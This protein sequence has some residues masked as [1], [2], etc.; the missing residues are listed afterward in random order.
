[1]QLLHK[2]LMFL[3][4]IPAF[5]FAQD[6]TLDGSFAIGSGPNSEVEGARELSNGKIIVYGYF[7][8]WSG[9][10]ANGII[11]LNSNCSIDQTFT[12]SE[13]VVMPNYMLP[14]KNGQL[15]ACTSGRIIKMNAN[16]SLDESFGIH[17][18]QNNSI[19]GMFEDAQGN[20]H[21]MGDLSSY[22]GAPVSSGFRI[23]TNGV[24]DRSFFLSTTSGIAVYDMIETL[25]GRL[26]LCMASNQTYKGISFPCGIVKVNK[27]GSIFKQFSLRSTISGSA[28]AVVEMPDGTLLI[29]GP[30]NDVTEHYALLKISPDGTHD[31]SFIPLQNVSFFGISDKMVLLSNNYVLLQGKFSYDGSA[32][33][34]IRMKSSG[35]LDPTFSAVDTEYWIY[36]MHL[37]KDGKILIGGAFEY[38]G[39][40]LRPFVARL[41]NRYPKYVTGTD[42]LVPAAKT[43][44]IKENPLTKPVIELTSLEGGSYFI[45]NSQGVLLQ[46]GM[47]LEGPNAIVLAL[48]E[49]NTTLL[50]LH[51]VGEN[52]SQSSYKI[53][54]EGH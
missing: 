39:T 22:D 52:A 43:I 14:L 46:S 18:I 48:T 34:I 33:Q 25:D 21:I 4:F 38:F 50:Y 11:R 23:F 26:V 3:V 45:Y 36:S 28:N 15:L 19:S 29:E 40:I 35:E 2:R 32:S 20:Y 12:P 5:V 24:L 27:D 41:R 30:F 49:S 37:Q 6:G 51:V 44:T 16:G 13:K 47:L 9:T 31:R 10:P 17:P 42:E 8:N 54:F 1:M 53:L 7:D